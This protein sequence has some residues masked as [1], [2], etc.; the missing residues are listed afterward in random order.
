M[1]ERGAK[2][3]KAKDGTV[4][5]RFF[6]L[7]KTGEPINLLEYATKIVSKKSVLGHVWYDWQ[8]NTAD[9][10]TDKDYIDPEAEFQEL[11]LDE[12]PGLERLSFLPEAK[13][14]NLLDNFKKMKFEQN[15]NIFLLPS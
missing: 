12:R 6:P 13:V 9:K 15:Q 3:A 11:I 14:D 2:Y 4:Y 7:T 1:E 5:Q 10:P 8:S